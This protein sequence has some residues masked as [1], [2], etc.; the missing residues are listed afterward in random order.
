MTMTVCGYSATSERS[1]SWLR[2]LY[3]KAATPDTG[4]GS[5]GRTASCGGFDRGAPA[6]LAANTAR[7]GAT[8][9]RRLPD[10]GQ[11]QAGGLVA[12][13]GLDG[14]REHRRPHPEDV[15]GPGRGHA[16]ADPG[17]CPISCVSEL[18]GSYIL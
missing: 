2:Y 8:D 3:R 15:E 11:G 9:A 17:D 16:G 14:Q 5:R 10:M 18:G 1:R 13:Q 6:R 7:G 12:P 4:V